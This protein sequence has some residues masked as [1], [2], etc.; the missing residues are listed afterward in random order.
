MGITLKKKKE[1]KSN[2][3]ENIETATEEISKMGLL[4]AFKIALWS[5]K[6]LFKSTPLPLII[7]SIASIINNTKDLVYT[8]IYAGLID[9]L[10]SI[11]STGGN[12]SDT[13]TYLWYI[14]IYQI[15]SSSLGVAERRSNVIISRRS[16]IFIDRELNKKLHDLGIS[17]L[18]DPKVNNLLIRT[19]MYKG[20]IL[21]FL[22]RA[23]DIVAEIIRL[24]II[25]GLVL[26]IL[27]IFSTV[28]LIAVIPMFIYDRYFRKMIWKHSYTSTESRRMAHSSGSMLSQNSSLNEIT[29]NGA[30]GFLDKKF[31]TFFRWF[32]D[33]FLDITGRWEAVAF[34]YN[35]SKDALMI[36]GYIEV[37]KLFIGKI[38]SVGDVAFW[39]RALQGYDESI[40]TL[41]TQINDLSEHALQFKD[42]FVLFHLEPRYKDGTIELEK[43]E[44]GP[45]I[46]ISN[47]SFRY[48]NAKK[49]VLKNISI[50][51]KSGEKIAIVGHN[52]AGKTTLI[53][54]IIGLYQ[55][56]KGSIKINSIP[57]ADYRQASL[58]KN[59]GV[60]F[61]DYNTY[62]HLTVRENIAIG[63]TSQ[64]IDEDKILSAAKAADAHDFIMEY[65][66]TYDQILSERFKNGI[67]PST[68]QWQKLAIARFFYRNAPL[69]IFDEPTAAIDALSEYKI[70]N[71]IYKF[72]E[73]KTVII[74]SHRFSTVRNADRIIMIEHGKII[75]QGSHQEL[76]DLNGKYAEAFRLQAEGYTR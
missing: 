66:K 56:D 15:A 9:K 7:Y 12:I 44:T 51:I 50:D 19:N 61:Q 54:L 11:I 28:V 64:R 30:Y 18:E 62:G 33:K 6:L 17:A 8:F 49:D 21:Q 36:W 76:M 10:I 4:E 16:N 34:S 23:I 31:F 41:V 52:G 63:D 32:E 20:N 1:N 40:T 48:P 14:F 74:I 59:V 72:F 26:S 29:V 2:Q 35:R 46:S 68:G 22:K 27:P 67:R 60:L 38:I 69:V 47:I 39:M 45:E 24:S 37:F 65:E 73:N 3:I 58:H 70:F 25:A 57:V 5:F 13:Y 55:T 75:E 53:K 71:R 42:A 43:L